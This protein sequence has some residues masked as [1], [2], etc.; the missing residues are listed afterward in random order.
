MDVENRLL[1][2][3]KKAREKAY[4]PYSRFKVGA[5]ILAKSGR[6][7][8]G[9]NVENASFGLACCAERVALFSAVAAGEREF[10]DLVVLTDGAEPATP[11]GA[12]RQA[13]NEFAPD[14]RV[15][16]ANLEGKKYRYLLKELLPHAFSEFKPE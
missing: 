12:C 5:A 2:Q 16:T 8:A 14:L 10:T 1:E 13:L 6:V 7:Y 9:C 4:A 15:V 11:C 3:A